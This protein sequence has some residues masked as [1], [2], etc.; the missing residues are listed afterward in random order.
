MVF[1]RSRQQ[2]HETADL[3]VYE[4]LAGELTD[5]APAVIE[6]LRPHVLRQS[7]PIG[8]VHVY[9][10]L[11]SSE[12]DCLCGLCSAWAGCARRVCPVL[13]TRCGRCVGSLPVMCG[14]TTAAGRSGVCEMQLRDQ[15]TTAV[16]TV[17]LVLAAWCSMC[18][19]SGDV[20]DLYMLPGS[21]GLNAVSCVS[22]DVM[23]QSKTAL[24]GIDCMLLPVTWMWGTER[25]ASCCQERSV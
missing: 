6:Q 12:H 20:V 25:S 11:Q 9:R 17:G 1:V 2:S 24:G 16:V 13:A 19:S 18:Y 4:P 8:A 15:R 10:G 14:G 7:T 22:C 5:A 3:L 23:Q 21:I